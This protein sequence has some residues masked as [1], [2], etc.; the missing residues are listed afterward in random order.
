LNNAFSEEIN[1]PERL[2]CMTLA[3]QTNTGGAGVAGPV[4]VSLA[5]TFQDPYNTP[6]L[7]DN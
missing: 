2:F 4:T 3:N 1:W 6:L 5:T 7:P